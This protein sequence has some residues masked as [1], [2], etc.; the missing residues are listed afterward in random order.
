MSSKDTDE[1]CLMHSKCDNIEIMVNDKKYEVIEELFESR[2]SRYQF[3][4]E[5]KNER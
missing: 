1:E 5:K 3:S 4:L 2:L